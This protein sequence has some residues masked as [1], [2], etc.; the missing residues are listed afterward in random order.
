MSEN[1]QWKCKGE[2]WKW[3]QLAKGRSRH[4]D[5]WTL[6]FSAEQRRSENTAA[7]ESKQI[8]KLDLYCSEITEEETRGLIEN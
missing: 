4:K 2:R 5:E 8:T 6:L 7:I 1:V 3:Q